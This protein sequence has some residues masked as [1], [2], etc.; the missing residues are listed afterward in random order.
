MSP[1]LLERIRSIIWLRIRLWIIK[2]YLFYLIKKIS[3]T[4]CKILTASSNTRSYCLPCLLGLQ[5]SS[6][7][8]LPPQWRHLLHCPTP[9]LP[10]VYNKFVMFSYITNKIFLLN[11]TT[12]G[13]ALS[14]AWWSTIQ[15]DIWPDKKFDSKLDRKSDE[16]TQGLCRIESALFEAW[17]LYIKQTKF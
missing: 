16:A 9:L 2:I 7:I 10:L 11:N 5:F 4:K 6:L 13:V 1:Y 17:Y 12:T 3:F 8:T 15:F 14:K